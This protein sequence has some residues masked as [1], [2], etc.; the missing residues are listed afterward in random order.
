MKHILVLLLLGFALSLCNLSER[1]HKSGS[2]SGSS[3]SSNSSSRSAEPGRPTAQQTA[4]LAG[5]QQ[6][7][8]ERQ[9]MSWTLPPKWTEVTNE[10]KS[11]VWSSGGSGA[12]SLNVNIS[13]MGD[14]FPTDSSL[15]A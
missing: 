11:F 12:A 15:Q 13:P 7:K 14:D 5:G 8:W 2:N 9:G 10:S 3:G 4:A 6:I 1:L